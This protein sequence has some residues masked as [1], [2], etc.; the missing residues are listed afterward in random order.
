MFWQHGDRPKHK[1][2]PS[3]SGEWKSKS[4]RQKAMWLILVWK[5]G[6][7]SSEWWGCGSGPPLGLC[8]L[9]KLQAFLSRRDRELICQARRV[10]GAWKSLRVKAWD[11]FQRSCHL[12]CQAPISDA[13]YALSLKSFPQFN[14]G[15]LPTWATS[16]RIGNQK[17]KSLFLKVFCVDEAFIKLASQ[18]V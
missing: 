4:I 3:P 1:P 12:L 14:Q 6:S 17:W 9:G 5:L 16:H 10:F 8:F 11:N 15:S 13:F 7:V 2:L 18:K